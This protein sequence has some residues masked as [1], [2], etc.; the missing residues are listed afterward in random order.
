MTK[1]P[2]LLLA[3][4]FVTCVPLAAVS[5]SLS[6]NT[7]GATADASAILDVSS[8][9]KGM[10]IPRLDKT[11]KTTIASPATGLLI[12]QTGPDSTGFYYYGS[13]GWVWLRD[14]INNDTLAWKINGNSNITASR[15]LGTLNDSALKFRVNNQPSGIVDSTSFNTSLGYGTLRNVNYAGAMQGKQNSAF[16][17]AGP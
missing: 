6:I 10:L 11:Q 2:N 8:N 4:V 1:I 17:Y 3:L 14:A 13:S 16:G 12:F 9:V 7:T 5:Q 15:F